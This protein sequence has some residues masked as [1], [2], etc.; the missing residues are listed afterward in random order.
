M[1]AGLRRQIQGMLDGQPVVA[2]IDAAKALRLVCLEEAVK[3]AKVNDTD[4]DIL[5]RAS[6]FAR[7]AD[8][9]LD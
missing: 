4:A 8:R 1:R 5:T 9:G 7:Y 2:P 6:R 3:V